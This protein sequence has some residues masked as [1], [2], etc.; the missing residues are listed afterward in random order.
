MVRAIGFVTVQ[1]NPILC[2]DIR[3]VKVKHIIKIY[4]MMSIGNVFVGVCKWL[5]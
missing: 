5:N 3:H 4:Q 1:H 2:K